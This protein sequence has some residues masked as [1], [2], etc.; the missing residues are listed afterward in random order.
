MKIGEAIDFKSAFAETSKNGNRIFAKRAGINGSGFERVNLPSPQLGITPKFSISKSDYF[1]TIGS[2]FARNI[3]NALVAEGIKCLTTGFKFEDALYEQTG[4]GARNGALNAY[5][6]ASMLD[7]IRLAKRE[8]PEHI[9]MLRLGDDEWCDMLMSGLRFLSRTEAQ[10]VRAMLLECYRSL[11]RADIVVVTLGYTE[12]W[13]DRQDGIFVNRSPGASVRTV[14]R[15]DRYSF[16]NMSASQVRECLHNIVGEVRE[17]TN[18]RAKVIFTVSPVPL[19]GTFTERDVIVANQYSKATLLTS[20][21]EVAGDYEFVD[22]FPSYEVV[23]NSP[24]NTTWEEDGVHVRPAVV[25]QIMKTFIS[26][27]IK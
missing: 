18:N 17:I 10:G 14:R 3:E 12:S 25:A 21:I 15:G 19:H 4:V 27:Y 2:C 26:E 20:A 24:R 11:G 13:F 6:P 9:A 22:Y 1:F 8:N 16:Q 5:T 23:S 7:L